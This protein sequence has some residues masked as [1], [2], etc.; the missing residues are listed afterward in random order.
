MRARLVPVIAALAAVLALALTGCNPAGPGGQAPGGQT[1]GGASATGNGAGTQGPGSGVTTTPRGT[2]PPPAAEPTAAVTLRKITYDWAVPSTPASVANLVKVPVAGPSGPALP[3]LVGIYAGDHPEANPKYHRMSF[4]FR[5][6][7]PSYNVGYVGSVTSEGKG[8]V[9][10]L[11]GNAFLRVGFT[12]AQAHDNN[13]SPTL[14]ASPKNPIGM[15]NLASYGFAGDFEGHVT[16]G[17]GLQVASGSDQVLKVRLGQL[18][19]GADL[20]VVFVDIQS[21]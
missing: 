20:Y 15:R 13:G 12:D 7:F 2:Q 19:R 10:P 4:Y 6:G 17:L 5:G 9:I 16:Y 14:K 11:Q 18:K 1:S 3:W 8:D 21:S